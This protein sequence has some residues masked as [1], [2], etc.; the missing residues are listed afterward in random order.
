VTITAAEPSLHA[1]GRRLHL[2]QQLERID[3]AL[4]A[5]REHDDDRTLPLEWRRY[6]PVPDVPREELR[7]TQA[8]LIQELARLD[9]AT[10]NS[11]P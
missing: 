2:R 1:A 3:T 8:A 10:P 5:W 6:P 7:R 4:M 11:L 9:S